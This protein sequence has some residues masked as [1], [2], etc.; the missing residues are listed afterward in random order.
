MTE[1]ASVSAKPAAEPK[2]AGRCTEGN[3]CQ[4]LKEHSCVYDTDSTVSMRSAES[5]SIKCYGLTREGE[6]RPCTPPSH[7]NFTI[8]DLNLVI[9]DQ[10]GQDDS[11][12]IVWTNASVLSTLASVLETDPSV[13]S[14]LPSI[15]STTPSV[16]VLEEVDLRYVCQCGVQMGLQERAATMDFLARYP[17]PYVCYNCRWRS[18]RF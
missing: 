9:G 1:S 2:A 13:V 17:A 3:F 15:V 4:N 5:A 14:T 18:V 8:D 16:Q 10:N 7:Q 6:D 12:S 11:P